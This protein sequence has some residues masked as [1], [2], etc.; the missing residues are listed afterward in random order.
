MTHGLMRTYSPSEAVDVVVVGTGAGGAPLLARL[1][2]AGLKVVALEAGR[3]WNA[4][5]EFAT[6][7]HAQHGIFWS[8]ERLSAGQHPLPFGRNNSGYGVGGGT[9][10]FTAYVPRPPA[11]D[12]RLRSDF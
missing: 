5:E 8:D 4:T 9:L 2:R 11:A 10:H 6:D 7:E 1:A 3:S 12:F